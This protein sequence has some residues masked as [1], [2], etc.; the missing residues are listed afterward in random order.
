M[1]TKCVREEWQGGLEDILVRAWTSVGLVPRVQDWLQVGE[2]DAPI[3]PFLICNA[4]GDKEVRQ[5]VVGIGLSAIKDY[6]RVRD[7]HSQR[8]VVAPIQEN[9]KRRQGRPPSRSKVH[10]LKLVPHFKRCNGVEAA[11]SKFCFSIVIVLLGF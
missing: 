1:V 5:V 7:I 9:P 10:R 3:Q 4:Y 2:V 11:N 6:L 8:G